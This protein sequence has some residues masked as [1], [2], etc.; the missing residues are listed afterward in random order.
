MS[1]EADL[2]FQSA[3]NFLHILEMGKKIEEIFLVY[4]IM[5]FQPFAGTYLYYEENSCDRQSTRY[6]TLLR[7]QI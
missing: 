7:S 3:Q 4:A 6:Q 2:C 1:Y 5:V